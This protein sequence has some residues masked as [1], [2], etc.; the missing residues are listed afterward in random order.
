MK[1]LVKSIVSGTY[2]RIV[3]GKV[4]RLSKED[5]RNF[6]YTIIEALISLNINIRSIIPL[7]QPLSGGTDTNE[8][9]ERAIVRGLMN[10]F[11]QIGSQILKNEGFSECLDVFQELRTYANIILSNLCV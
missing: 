11:F 5:T 1:K 8:S 7:D 3:T 9:V 4:L 2:Y 6:I 10:K